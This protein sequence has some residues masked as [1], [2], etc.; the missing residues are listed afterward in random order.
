MTIATSGV[1]QRAVPEETRPQG[2]VGA[3]VPR[4]DAW[5]KVTGK[6][7]YSGDLTMPG[8]LHA[9]ILWS[10][11][12]HALIKNIDTAPAKAMKG[13]HAVLTAE[14]IPGPNR[15]GVAVL[16]QRVL[17]EGKVRSRAD[18][19]AL[20]A[21]ESEELAEEA[22]RRICVEY[23]P[24]PSVHS[25]EDALAEGAPA[26]HEA[27][28]LYQHT[29]VRKGDVLA[30]FRDADVI[31]ERTYRTQSMD[32]APMEP[33]AGLAYVDATG[34][35]NVLTATQYPFRDRR[36]IAPNVGLPMN[37]VRVVMMPVGGGFGRKDDITT[38][39]HAGLLAV[40]TKRPVRLVY[41]R[42]E[43]LFA[44]TKRHPFLIKYKSG[45]RADGHLTAVEASI[46][47]DTGPYCSLG[48]Y[49]VKKAGI[50]ATGPY[51]VPNVSVDTYTVY[52]NNLIA[53]AMRGF[54][55]LQIAVAHEAQM[56]AL[57]ERLH[58]SPL[59]FRLI[60]CLKPGLSTATGQVVN[61]GTG[62]QATLERIQEYMT[63][64]GLDWT[65]R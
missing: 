5:E 64:K 20:V 4:L 38:E 49:V 40:V 62:I 46:W 1:D 28:N 15:F 11:H 39:I 52:T 42:E 25:V 24:L 26:V 7:R 6:T 63:E 56:D 65:R 54:G 34:V 47:G 36:Q 17:A 31:V 22:A 58:M 37:H 41:T 32:H 53:G 12:A 13:V 43:S 57:A 59:Q 18:A 9:K 33:E 35:L 2:L 8:M 60:N 55:V 29:T 19:V 61:E 10:E 45:A 14:D 50:H 27:G 48:M 3:S 16:D 21:A 44:N 30:G 23:E 51:F